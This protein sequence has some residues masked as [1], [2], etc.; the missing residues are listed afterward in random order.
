MLNK[1]IDSAEYKMKHLEIMREQSD[2]TCNSLDNNKQEK[3][4]S[5]SLSKKQLEMLLL[6]RTE[7][8][9]ECLETEDTLR[10]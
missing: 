10:Q 9:E 2:E 6:E 3:T 7:S 5:G 1:D 4:K 8:L